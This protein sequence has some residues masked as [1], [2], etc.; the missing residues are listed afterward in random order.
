M[1]PHLQRQ[2]QRGV[3]VI[4]ALLLTTLAVTIVTSLFWL[5]QV[6]V[7]SMENQRLQ[8]QTR[9][10]LRGALDLSRLILNQDFNDSPLVTQLN[11]IWATPLEETRLDDYV[12]RE[13]QQGENFNATLSGR[14]IDAQSRYNLANLAG[15]G[16]QPNTAEIEVFERLLNN[17]RLD[18]SLARGVADLVTNAQPTPA[19]QT[20]TTTQPVGLVRV[21]DLLA[22]AGFTPQAVEQL[23]DYVIILPSATPLNVNTAPAE[24]LSALVPG[25]SLSDAAAM[26]STRKTV[27]YLNTGSFTG[28]SQMQGKKAGVSFSVRSDYFLAYSRVKLDRATLETQSLLKRARGY[29]TVE[30]IREY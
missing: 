23:R 13:R 21:E 3:A 17:L 24:L 30:W 5:Q 20:T 2:R 15:A 10:I 11:G 27:Y 14:M 4:T 1:K 28:V 19:Q 18:S 26:V 16:K 25:L 6:Q 7:R 9:W 12:E 29:T 22:V 8:L